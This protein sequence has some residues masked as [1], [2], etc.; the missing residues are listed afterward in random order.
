MA[1]RGEEESTAFEYELTH[2]PTCFFKN[3]KMRDSKKHVLGNHLL[4]GSEVDSVVKSKMF[5]V[6][7]GGNLLHKVQWLPNSTYEDVIQQYIGYVN[8]NFGSYA[9]TKVVF[10]GYGNGPSTKDHEHTG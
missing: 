5:C 7:D 2:E 9:F 3:G 1:Q 6:V 8:K 4:K 10:D